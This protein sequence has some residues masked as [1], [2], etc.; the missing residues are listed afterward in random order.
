[1]DDNAVAYGSL[2]YERIETDGKGLQQECVLW[3]L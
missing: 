1:M 2:K 3:F